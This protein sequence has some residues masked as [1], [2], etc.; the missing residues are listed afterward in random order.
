M[1]DQ[2]LVDF[3]LDCLNE[4]VSHMR[5][6]DLFKFSQVCKDFHAIVSNVFDFNRIKNV[7]TVTLTPS[8]FVC[9]H[10]APTHE[11]EILKNAT[12][13]S[14]IFSDHKVISIVCEGFSILDDYE[15]YSDDFYLS[16]SVKNNRIHIRYN[17]SGY[18]N[19]VLKYD[20]NGKW[21]PDVSGIRFIDER[22]YKNLPV[23]LDC[24]EE[25]QAWKNYCDRK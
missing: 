1:E 17:K 25:L 5:L 18:D 11:E 9:P 23:I 12:L 15:F 10:W 16:L 20:L 6:Q 7:S 19:I 21:F 13:H 24:L 2:S 22:Y 14:V 8:P 4:L 3:P